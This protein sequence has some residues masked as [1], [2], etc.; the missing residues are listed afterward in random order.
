MTEPQEPDPDAIEVIGLQPMKAPLTTQVR[1]N[2]TGAGAG[3]ETSVRTGPSVGIPS[4][5]S[6]TGASSAHRNPRTRT[7]SHGAL[8]TGLNVTRLQDPDDGTWSESRKMIDFRIQQC[9][10]GV[11]SAINHLGTEGQTQEDRAMWEESQRYYKGELERWT[12]KLKD[13]GTTDHS[14]GRSSLLC[15]PCSGKSSG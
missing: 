1:S 14:A 12:A 3:T 8:A 13:G 11:Q 4:S 6:P 7:G 15:D 10:V 5:L 2:I 9:Q